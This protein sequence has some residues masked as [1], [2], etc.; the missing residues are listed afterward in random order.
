MGVLIMKKLETFNIYFAL[1][2][3]LL[4]TSRLMTFIAFPNPTVAPD[5]PTYFV[6]K[7]LDFSLVSFS[8]DASRG[9][10]VPFVYAFM[11]NLEI[12]ELFQLILSAIAWSFLLSTIYMAKLIPTKENNYLILL[13]ALLGSS[14]QI[15]QHDTAVLATSITNSIFISLIAF[16]LKAKYVMKSQKWNLI[17]AISCAA[18]LMIQKTSFIPIAITLSFLLFFKVF[19]NVS[20]IT[21][22]FSISILTCLTLYAV[23]VGSNVNSNWQISYS[24]QTLLWHLGGQSPS[25][26]EFSAYLQKRKAPTCVTIEAPY[27]NINT[28]IGK[29]LNSCPEARP[30]L[31]KGI[32]RDFVNFIVSNPTEAAKLSIYGMGAALTSSATNYGSAVSITPKFVDDIFFG[33]TT[34]DLR[35]ANVS[36]QVSGLNVFQSGSPFWLS[37]PFV[38]WFSLMMVSILLRGRE[39][40]DDSFLY[41]ILALCL[42]QSVLVVILLPSEWV[43]QTTPFLISAL[44]S[45]VVLTFKNI[46]A[47]FSKVTKSGK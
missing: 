13:I 9:W 8:G 15:I 16:L 7:F 2:I 35:S 45:I 23:F 17:A 25:A 47:V 40:K 34:P 22:V 4:I 3:S 12:L 18:L 21:K 46:T 14:S 37:V 24:G 26:V 30:Y 31:K 19:K 38:G 43:R 5:S 20:A 32:Q 39:R 6:G 28:S 11:P 29:I 27:Q 36:D 41:W 44:I 10:P 1:A 42:I 33:S